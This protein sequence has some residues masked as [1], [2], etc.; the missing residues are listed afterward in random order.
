MAKS[1]PNIPTVNIIT[2]DPVTGHVTEGTV[3]GLPPVVDGIFARA[4]LLQNIDDATGGTT[5][6]NVGNVIGPIWA[7]I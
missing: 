5:Y 1:N 4:C 3:D 6:Q 7:P 2:Q